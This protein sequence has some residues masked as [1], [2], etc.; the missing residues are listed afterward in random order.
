M[1]EL[2]STKTKLP[3]GKNSS[4]AVR[5]TSYIITEEKSLPTK[6]IDQWE[7]SQPYAYIEIVVRTHLKPIVKI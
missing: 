3:K 6:R 5:H 1:R 7:W 2:L 4:G